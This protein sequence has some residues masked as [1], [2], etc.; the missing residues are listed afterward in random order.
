[1]WE[2][3]SLADAVMDMDRDMSV[4]MVNQVRVVKAGLCG[5]EKKP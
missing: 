1:M 5:E 4:D 2:M 3:W